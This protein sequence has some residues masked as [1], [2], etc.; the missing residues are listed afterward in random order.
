MTHSNQALSEFSLNTEFLLLNSTAICL[1]P[2]LVLND[3]A[4]CKLAIIF[5]YGHLPYKY[6]GEPTIASPNPGPLLGW[7]DMYL[8]YMR[9]WIGLRTQM[10]LLI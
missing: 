1:R 4:A 3:T 2:W 6:I 7:C 5:H 10:S 9:E 8:H